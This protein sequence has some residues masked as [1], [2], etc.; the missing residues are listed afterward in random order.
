MQSLDTLLYLEMEESNTWPL[1]CSG[2]FYRLSHIY[3]QF[4]LSV[5]T[6]SY[7]QQSGAQN[8]AKLCHG[9][10]IINVVLE[11]LKIE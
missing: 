2:T 7:N 4:C 9:E 5:L 6:P 3:T 11:D 1:H 8:A 10:V